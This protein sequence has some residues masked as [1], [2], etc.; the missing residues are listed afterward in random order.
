MKRRSQRALF[1]YQRFNTFMHDH[2]FHRGRKQFC[3][4]CLQAFSPE[5]ILK[6][7]INNCFKINCR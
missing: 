6:C 3:R 1:P 4:Y 5:E 7:H 2:T